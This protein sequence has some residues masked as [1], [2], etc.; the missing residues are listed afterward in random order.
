MNCSHPLLVRGKMDKEKE[1]ERKGLQMGRRREGGKEKQGKRGGEEENQKPRVW[2]GESA[3]C[4]VSRWGAREYYRVRNP[5][6]RVICS[7]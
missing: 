5:N 3:L 4:P 1:E 7:L 2:S 6:C